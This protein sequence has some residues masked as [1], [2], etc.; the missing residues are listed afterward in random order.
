MS[1]TEIKSIVTQ[2]SADSD[3]GNLDAV[4]C[5][6]ADDYVFHRAPYPDLVGKEANRK[7]DEALASAFSNAHTTIHEIAVE[8]N[9]AAMH[10]TWQADH[11]GT[12]PFSG[13]PASGK[14]V[15]VSGCMLFHWQDEK[16]IEQWDF[17]DGLGLRQQLDVL[18]GA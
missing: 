6:M 7:G 14:T 12:T 16:L 9:T 18:A 13:I 4:Y 1:P 8:G 11:T 10:Y 17:T 2:I 3:K 15:R 5:H